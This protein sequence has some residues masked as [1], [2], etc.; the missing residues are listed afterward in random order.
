M[1]HIFKITGS[2]ARRWE[3]WKQSLVGHQNL[4]LAPP[5]CLRHSPVSPWGAACGSELPALLGAPGSPVL[6]LTGVPT[7]PQGAS[8]R[9]LL[10]PRSSQTSGLCGLGAGHHG[11]QHKGWEEKGT[12]LLTCCALPLGSICSR[13]AGQELALAPPQKASKAAGEQSPARPAQIPTANTGPGLG[14]GRGQG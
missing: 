2:F 11:E 5:D 13:G 8:G 10:H 4:G 9:P 1:H 12:T 3:S 7:S 14:P 6:L